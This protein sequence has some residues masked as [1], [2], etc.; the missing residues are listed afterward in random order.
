MMDYVIFY[1]PNRYG[2]T[3]TAKEGFSVLQ[4]FDSQAEETDLNPESFGQKGYKK[5]KLL[6]TCPI[7]SVTRRAHAWALWQ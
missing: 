6:S 4:P 2:E 1:F 7:S 5:S 3:I